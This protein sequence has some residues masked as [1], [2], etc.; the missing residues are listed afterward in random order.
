VAL[1]G[2]SDVSQPRR[3]FSCRLGCAHLLSRDGAQATSSLTSTTSMA[4]LLQ[5]IEDFKGFAND[6]WAKMI[7]TNEGARFARQT[8]YSSS[9]VNNGQI[10][11]PPASECKCGAQPNSCPPGPPGP[12]GEPGEGGSDGENGQHGPGGT[13]PIG[14][15]GQAGA[16][17]IPGQQGLP[18]QNGKRGTGRS[19]PP[20]QPGPPGQY[21]QPGQNGYAGN[22]GAPGQQGSVGPEGNA[23]NPS[24]INSFYD[25]AVTDLGEFKEFADDAWNTMIRTASG[26]SQLESL[27]HFMM[28]YA[29]EKKRRGG[30]CNCGAQPN[31][32]PVG[33]PGPP[34]E[35]GA[36]GEDGP[37]GQP[38]PHGNKG[39]GMVGMPNEPVGCIQC[40]PGPAGP[41][42]PDGLIGEAGPDGQNGA[43]GPPGPNGNPGISGEPGDAGERGEP[44]APG[45]SRS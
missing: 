31:N 42:G 21:G 41:P 27:S 20:G 38:A 35:N 40:P 18:G 34:G 29:R 17:G 5:N 26:Q 1:E 15:Q 22:D 32:C 7:L 3:I 45:T 25:D 13:G 23:G 16:P 4:T 33:Q 39:I 44:G 10:V 6:A 12:P 19:G 14:D 37:P 24:D 30:S 36:P 11:G 43:D 8:Y 9:G 2:I 28:M